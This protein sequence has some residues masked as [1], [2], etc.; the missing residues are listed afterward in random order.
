MP[1]I[2][3]EGDTRQLLRKLQ[4][5]KDIDK[6]GI[7]K[8]IGNSLRSSTVERFST[9]K[10]PDGKK[11]RNS[12][13]ASENGGVTLTE[14][15]RLKNSIKSYGNES[16]AAV[17]TNTIYA[18]THQFGARRTIRA[19]SPKGLRFKVS[20]GKWVTKNK[21]KVNIPARPFLGLSEEDQ[22]E[23]RGILE[24]ALKDK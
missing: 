9:Q 5:L 16:G 3:L 18:G 15:A 23:I 11:W 17:G 12:I 19:E 6:K 14:T 4:K 20:G 10:A 22:E 7:N 24:D 13:R 2:R 21:V 8:A 1:S